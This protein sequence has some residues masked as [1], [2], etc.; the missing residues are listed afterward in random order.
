[1]SSFAPLVTAAAEASS[2][3]INRWVVGGI[4]LGSFLIA[5]LILLS[6]GGGREHT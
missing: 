6:I 5:M 4:I 3:G 1:M 2:G